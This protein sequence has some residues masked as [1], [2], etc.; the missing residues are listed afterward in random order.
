MVPAGLSMIWSN[1]SASSVRLSVEVWE[2]PVRYLINEFWTVGSASGPLD[3]RGQLPG[4]LQAAASRVLHRSSHE[5]RRRRLRSVHGTG[6][7]P[8]SGGSDGP[9]ADR[10]RHQPVEHPVDADPDWH[11]R[12]SAKLRAGWTRS[13]GTRG[14]STIPELLA[15]Y[16]ERTLRHICALRSW[17]IERAPLD[18]HP[19]PR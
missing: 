12:R 9:P 5:A 13:G 8:G 18:W 17:L 2:G 10:Q 19:G 3:S 11:R 15:F 4:L 7:D 6:D 14:R 1:T 16:S